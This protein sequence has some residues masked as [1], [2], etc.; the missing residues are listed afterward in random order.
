MGLPL[1][2]YDKNSSYV[3]GEEQE[4]QDSNASRLINIFS[5]VTQIALSSMLPWTGREWDLLLLG[6]MRNEF[7]ILHLP[8]GG[9]VTLLNAEQ[10]AEK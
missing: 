8:A 3:K 6:H 1:L 2:Q 4:Q 7:C 9:S 5:L 10:S